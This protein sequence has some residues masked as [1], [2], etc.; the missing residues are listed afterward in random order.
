MATNDLKDQP[1]HV[2]MAEFYKLWDAHKRAGNFDVS[3]E[4]ADNLAALCSVTAPKV[5]IKTYEPPPP[6]PKRMVR[7]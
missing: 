6:P 7:G 3:Q 1:E 4:A 5:K 2:R